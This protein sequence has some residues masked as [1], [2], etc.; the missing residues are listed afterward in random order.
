MLPVNVVLFFYMDTLMNSLGIDPDVAN[1]AWHWYQIYIFS[2]PF[3]ALFQATWKFLSAQNVM[4][5]CFVAVSFGSIVVLPISLVV[6]PPLLGYYGTSLAIVCF[7][8]FE[9]VSLVVYLWLKRPHC[10][11]TWPG[12]SAW[13]EA[14]RWEQFS[15]FLVRTDC[16]LWVYIRSF[17]IQSRH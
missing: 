16:G 13:K 4:I 17:P 14:I 9:A 3:Y 12:L 1:L 10:P 7:Q 11:G 5:P 6:W 15:S 2:I 8:A